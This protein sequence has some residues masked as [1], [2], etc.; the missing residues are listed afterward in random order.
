MPVPNVIDIT[1]LIAAV[2]GTSPNPATKARQEAKT[3]ANIFKKLAVFENRVESNEKAA[4]NLKVGSQ[5]LK[6]GFDPKVDNPVES[7]NFMLDGESVSPSALDIGKLIGDLTGGVQDAL[8]KLSSGD[9][10]GAVT[11]LLTSITGALPVGELLGT[12]SATGSNAV[13]TVGSSVGDLAGS[14]T[15][16]GSGGLPTVG[17]PPAGTGDVPFSPISGVASGAVGTVGSNVGEGVGTATGATGGLPSGIPGGLPI[18]VPP[19]PALS[20]D[21]LGP[22]TDIV[23]SL[24]VVGGLLGG[25]G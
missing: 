13:G 3:I 20:G 14:L 24:P 8:S 23:G 5:N 6:L 11:G 9:P 2:R 17:A 7:V 4:V 1:S 10:V 25:L 15:G 16:L 21:L 19:T 12:G 22:V 18:A